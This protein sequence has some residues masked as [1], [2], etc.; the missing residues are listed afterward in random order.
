MRGLSSSVGGFVAEW[1]IRR[2]GLEKAVTGVPHLK[3]V[4]F[5]LLPLL[6]LSFYFPA[7]VW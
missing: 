7:A 5:F 6:P 1:V 2:Q 3:G 4:S